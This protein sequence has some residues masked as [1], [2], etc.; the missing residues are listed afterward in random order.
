[1]FRRNFLVNFLV[2]R[3]GDSLTNK[4][5]YYGLSPELKELVTVIEN[6]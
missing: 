1:M 4:N 5:C 2:N 6:S 3:V